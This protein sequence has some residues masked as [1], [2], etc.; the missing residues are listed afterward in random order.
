MGRGGDWCIVRTSPG[1][2]LPVARSL[3]Q[4]GFDAWSPAQTITRRKPRTKE[5]RE[6]A[7]PIM[8]TFVFVRASQLHELARV[9]ALP[10]N[11][12]PGFSLFRYHGRYPLLADQ[13][14]AS[15]RAAEEKARKAGL[16]KNHRHAF[17]VGQAVQVKEGVG[18]GL[19]GIV[20]GGDGSF[21]LVAFG[22]TFRMKIATFLLG[23][24]AVQDAGK[25]AA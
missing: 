22:G 17:P 24:D 9:L 20:E 18:A 12:H 4:A 21:A 2:T 10:V 15:L 13:D 8:P 7:V 23:T 11:P 3:Q 25:I 14:V 19:S 1:R 6:I 16:K 5:V